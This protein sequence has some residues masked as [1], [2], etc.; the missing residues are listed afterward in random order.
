MWNI[1]QPEASTPASGSTTANSAS[2]TSWSLTVGN[3]RRS[4]C[5]RQTDGDRAESEEE[6]DLDHG[7]N[8]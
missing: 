1:T 4:E 6:S 3:S 8:R 5:R 7:V 2:P